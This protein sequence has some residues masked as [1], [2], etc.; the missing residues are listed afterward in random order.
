L[1]HFGGV[2]KALNLDYVPGHITSTTSRPP[3]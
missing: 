2:P 1:R 3:S